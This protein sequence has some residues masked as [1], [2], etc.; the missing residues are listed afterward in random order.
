MQ[1]MIT[2]NKNIEIFCVVDESYKN[3]DTE[4]EKNILKGLL[5]SEGKKMCRNR[6]GHINNFNIGTSFWTILV[7]YSHSI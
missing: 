3:F 6:K 7:T 2:N 4:I 5:L 1:A